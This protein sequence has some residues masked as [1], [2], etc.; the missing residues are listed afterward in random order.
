MARLILGLAVVLTV[1]GARSAAA[2]DKDPV[3]LVRLNPAIV[4]WFADPDLLL[5][6][7]PL[8]MEIY[9]PKADKTTA[10]DPVDTCA[11]L[12]AKQAEGYY[13]GTTIGMARETVVSDVCRLGQRYATATF[14]ATES[15]KHTLH[16]D[17]LDLWSAW[18]QLAVSA[19][20]SDAVRDAVDRGVSLGA[21]REPS[22]A[23]CGPRAVERK[24]PWTITA[25]NKCDGLYLSVVGEEYTGSGKMRP[26]VFYHLNA[27]GGSL[28]TGGYVAVAPHPASGVWTPLQF[29][30][31]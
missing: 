22:L 2:L 18:F 5:R 3:T 13:A 10:T 8:E 19:N 20:V 23:N 28:R 30:S 1:F 9:D 29:L 17:V 11:D 16:A 14:E 26:I 31:R 6:E 12:E 7:D 25:A 15:P 4:A 24:D 27:T 21:F